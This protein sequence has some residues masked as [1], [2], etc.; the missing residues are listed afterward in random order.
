[1]TDECHDVSTRGARV[2]EVLAGYLQA[3][4][5]G[6]APSRQEL[7]ARHPDLAAE[8][9]AFFADHDELDQLARPAPAATPLPSGLARSQAGEPTLAPGETGMVPGTRMRYFGDYELLEEIGRGGMG[10][11][12][13]A[14]QVSLNRVVALKMILAGQLASEADVRRFRSEAEAAGNL[15]HS[16]IVPIYEVGE[17]QGQH[18]FSMKLVEGGS[19]ASFSREPKASVP[20]QRRAARLV[21]T[22]ARA[23]HHAHQRGILHRDLKPANILLAPAFGRGSVD[24]RS[25]DLAG[26]RPQSGAD[27]VPYVTD[28]GLARRVEGGGNLTGSGAVVGT[29][30]YMPPEQAGGKKD[31]TTA[32]DVYSLGAIV[33]E[34]LTGRPP[35]RAETPLDTLMHVLAQEPARPRQLNPHVDRDLET[36]CLKCLEKDPQC[37]YATAEALAADLERWLAGEPIQARPTGTWERALKWARRR[38]AAS[39]LA[40][41]SGAS[42]LCL[43][44]LAGFLWHNAEVRAEAVQDLQDARREE[45]AA[46]DEAAAQERRAVAKRAEVDRL[47][48]IADRESQRA[49]E[50]QETGRHTLY[51]ADMQLAHAAWETDSVPG[52]LGLLERHRPK[53]DQPDLRG[54]EWHYL[55]RLGHQERY[56]LRAY[57]PGPKPGAAEADLLRFAMSDFNPVLVAVSPDGKTL[58]SASAAERIKLWDLAT[59]KERQ[60]LGPAG[61]VA[62]LA[63]ASDSKGLVAVTV[64][65][66]DKGLPIIDKDALNAVMTGKAKPTVQPLL[67]QLALQTLPLD[68]KVGAAE[69][70]EPARLKAPLSVL[71]AGPAAL[72]LLVAGF[73][74]LP[75]QRIVSPM[76]VAASP[77]GKLLAVGGLVSYGALAPPFKVKQVGAVLLW[78]VAAAQEKALLQGHNGPVSGLAFAPDRQALA[79]AGFD[80][81]V[82]LWD[83]WGGGVLERATL[84][85]HTAPVFAVAF[86]PDG[87]RLASGAVDGIVKVWDLAT[88]QL[89]LTCKG[90]RQS[91]TS[92]AW[93]PDSQALVSA[94]VDGLV[95]VWGL[96][97]VQGPPTLKGFGG[98]VKAL[99]FM[100]DGKALAGVDQSGMLLVSDAATGATQVRHKLKVEY[101]F[102][103]CATFSPDGRTLAGGGPRATVELYDVASGQQRLVLPGHHGVVYSV[104][105]APDGKTLAAGSGDA[106]KSGE[107]TLWDVPPGKELPPPAKER[108]REPGPVA[109]RSRHKLKGYNS[110]VQAVAWSPD[111]KMLAGAAKDGTVKLW[112][113]ATGKERLSF[114]A[115]PGKEQPGFRLGF[116]G[117]AGVK[118]V[119]FSPDGRRLAVAAGTTITL[120]E[121]G[122][123][124]VLLTMEGY[125]HEADSLT[126]SPDGRRLASGGGEGELG[127]GGG[128]KLWDTATGLE[129]MRMGG[130]SDVISC[131][132]FS[133]DSGRLA[134]AAVTGPGIM[135]MGQSGGEVTVW[136]GR[137]VK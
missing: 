48:A 70:L 122:T 3:V 29:P 12:F 128:V 132:A 47:Q 84:R 134:T 75:G 115:G 79:T 117:G 100:A 129:V 99:A 51:A 53:A 44:I 24:S 106:Q 38:P 25:Q 135:F 26:P 109:E 127:R 31:L 97:V 23:V 68:G 105:F 1:M 124:K 92:L 93:T 11:V 137:P 40:A 59:G 46:K 76:A 121:A 108:F 78:D 80:K 39:A 67:A 6:Q 114:Q 125:S 94:S 86:S 21:A 13:K 65:N 130:P 55:W 7:L 88:N 63:F 54:F 101:G 98:A 33:Y 71:A 45:K 49:R 82:K 107:I 19:L 113:V 61:P 28:F 103:F 10:V 60:S 89:Q 35:F 73:I 8:L 50:A 123:G 85:G 131:M 36:V 120:R 56:T 62:A 126:F 27:W 69:A 42:A 32:A 133:R 64:K 34:L 4:D 22:V 72:R 77:D 136:D 110:H 58:A 90:H 91:V 14:R 111:G 112:E 74:P 2:N 87:K 104:A 52:L 43:L 96:A 57:M 118:A 116:L 9:Q 16:N 20:D 17:H 83:V 15:D 66:Q 119:A 18:Y 41:V 95:K 81:T 5:A 102:N 30:A 37:R